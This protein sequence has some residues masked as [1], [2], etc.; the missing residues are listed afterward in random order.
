MPDVACVNT[1]CPEHEIPKEN[2]DDYP[3]EEIHCGGCGGE[4]V[5][6]T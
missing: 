2:P 1:D 5:E 4:V 3:V 6:V